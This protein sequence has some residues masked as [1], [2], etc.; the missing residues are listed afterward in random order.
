MAVAEQ[1]DELARVLLPGDEQHL[2]DAG[3]LQQ[4]QRVVDHRPAA[5]RQQVLVRDARQLLEPRRGAACAD[6]SFHA[7]DATAA[8]ASWPR[9]AASPVIPAVT[10][11][12][13]DAH[14]HRR[15]AV[16]AAHLQAEERRQRPPDRPRAAE[17]P[18]VRPRMSAGASAATT[19]CEVGTQS[20][21]PTTKIRIT[22]AITRG[23]AVP[24]QEQERDAHHRHR[25]AELQRSGHVDV[26]RVSRSWNTVTSSGLTIIRMP[27]A[28]GA[29]WWV[30]VTEIGSSVSVAT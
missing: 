28:A 24:V 23:G 4:L 8:S 22:S 25:D 30:V 29:R 3:A 17:E 7:A 19:A 9:A 18:H 5:D 6:Q 15:V 27:H 12:D 13:R 10:P 2:A 21:S 20:I 11:S 14:P 16:V 1:V 26:Q